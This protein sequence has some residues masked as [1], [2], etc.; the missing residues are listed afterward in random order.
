MHHTLVNYR[1]LTFQH[2]ILSDQFLFS[3]A[4]FQHNILKDWVEDIFLSEMQLS[5]SI[6]VGKIQLRNLSSIFSL[7]SF[8]YD[9]YSFGNLAIIWSTNSSSTRLSPHFDQLVVK[10]KITILA[11]TCFI[12]QN[13]LTGSSNSLMFTSEPPLGANVYL[14]EL[15]ISIVLKVRL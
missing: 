1:W 14:Y 12:F 8:Q 5:S 2:P 9:K 10:F 13:L 4:S 11:H 15:K 7:Q 6:T 3:M